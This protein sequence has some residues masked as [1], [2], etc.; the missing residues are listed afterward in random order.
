MSHYHSLEK[1]FTEI[2][3][4]NGASAI[5]HWDSEVMMPSGGAAIRGEQLATLATLSHQRMCDARLADWMA[6]AEQESLNSWQ[7]ANLREMK[8]EIAHATALPDDLVH[9]LSKATSHSEHVWREARP[10]NDWT[11]FAEAFKPVLTLVREA[12]AAKSLALGLSPYDALLDSYD[13]GIR[14]GQIDG[15]FAE[16]ELFLPDFITQAIE[17]QHSQSTL[18]PITDRIPVAN[19]SKL[20][21]QFMRALG[22]DFNHG[23]IDTSAHPFCGGVAGDVRLT[24]HYSE[25]AFTESLYGVLH[26]TGHALYEMYLPKDWLHQPVGKARGMSM[27]E[28]QSLL[29]EMQLC[30]GEDFLRY[31]LPI[32]TQTFGVSGEAWAHENVYRSL[33]QVQRSLIRVNADEATYPLHIMLRYKLEKALLSGDLLVDD[34]PAAWNELMQSYLGITPDCIG[35]GCMQDVHWPGGAIGYFP[36]YTIGAM[37][38]AQLFDKIMQDNPNHADLVAAGDFSHIF[39]WLHTHIHAQGSLHSTQELLQQATGQALNV[40]IYKSHLRKRY[41]NEA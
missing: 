2:D 35:N 20:G 36:T 24:T 41:L 40:E 26:E 8:R 15:Y 34:L 33:T 31:A 7:R 16:L 4:I 5:L 38:A 17:Y 11:A 19:Q 21:Q 9:A 27:H 30:R 32:I 25:N 28:S 37:I 29:V 23:R 13:P 12:A 10:N 6:Q 22:F 1:H 18:T 14:M 39:G 3:A